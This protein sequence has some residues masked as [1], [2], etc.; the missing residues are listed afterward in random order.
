[1]IY[2]A[3]ERRH[4]GMPVVV[5]VVGRS[6]SGKTTLLEKLIPE[7]KRRGYRVGTI[8][9]TKEGFAIDIEGKDSWRHKSSGA[10]AVILS[11][12]SRVALIKDVEK[13]L[14]IEEMV[15]NFLE[16]MDIV[17]TEGYKKGGTLKIEICRKES[18]S[19]E[20][21]CKD[22]RNL[23]ALVTNLEMNPSIPTFALEETE[24]LADFL[25]NRYL[26]G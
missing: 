23:I 10:Q 12:P 17:L 21:L 8:K 18:G 2:I 22:D 25:E 19:Q 5:S 7:I 6:G 20:I 11:S 14:G 4:K 9:H 1:L 24:K 13:E 15:K 26:K 3:I 16:D